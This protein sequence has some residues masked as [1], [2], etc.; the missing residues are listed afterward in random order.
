[1]ITPVAS[2]CQESAKGT[3]M[4]EYSIVASLLEL[5]EEHSRAHG[6]IKIHKVIIALG[7]RSGVEPQLLR[8]AFDTFKLDSIGAES[9][10][11]IEPRAVKL[12][13]LACG[14]EFHP[15]GM[16][17]GACKACGAKNPEMIEGKEM[18]LLSLEMEIPDEG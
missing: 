7:E 14:V 10:L 15:E 12:R 18:H 9:E 13:C 16:E 3:T 1:M 8:S 11:V 4:H 17:F 5:C 2:S 6:A